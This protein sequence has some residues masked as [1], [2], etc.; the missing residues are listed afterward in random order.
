M[1]RWGKRR[2]VILSEAKNLKRTTSARLRFFG[3]RPQNDRLS[4]VSGGATR[5]GCQPVPGAI[6]GSLG[7]E[8]RRPGRAALPP[9]RPLPRDALRRA[10]RR[11]RSHPRLLERRH[12]H[13]AGHPLRRARFLHGRPHARSRVV[14]CLPAQ[15]ERR[16]PRARRCPPRRL[17]WRGS[18]HLP[19]VL[20]PPRR[21]EAALLVVSEAEPRRH[22]TEV[23]LRWHRRL[24]RV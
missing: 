13:P 11:P 3:L 12:R 22:T 21:V 20:A 7:D 14:G 4:I 5:D 23:L 17:L 19:R 16:A 8:E 15:A 1:A 6:Q 9:R 18:P 2:S 10:H 24:P